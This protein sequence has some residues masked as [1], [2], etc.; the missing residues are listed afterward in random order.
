MLSARSPRKLM[1]A[2]ESLAGFAV[3]QA[4]MALPPSF[5][6]NRWV[7]IALQGTDSNATDLARAR[8]LARVSHKVAERWPGQPLCLQRSLTLLL[9]LRL[10]GIGGR[11]RIGVRRLEN[12]VVA[13]AWIEVAG[14]PVNESPQVCAMYG[15]YE[16]AGNAAVRDLAFVQARS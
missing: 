8:T 11:L 10:H 16:V 9:L 3:S 1:W 13:H 2:A 6:L 15:V 5:L 7:N 14:Q 12:E 4:V